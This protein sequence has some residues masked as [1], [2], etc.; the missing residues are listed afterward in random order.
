MSAHRSFPPAP[1][2]ESAGDYS[3]V[4]PMGASPRGI[5]PFSVLSNPVNELRAG[6]VPQGDPKAFVHWTSQASCASRNAS[7]QSPFCKRRAVWSG[8]L[9]GQAGDPAKEAGRLIRCCRPGAVGDVPE[10]ACQAALLEEVVEGLPTGP[11]GAGGLRF[12]LHG[13]SRLPERAVVARILHGNP[14]R[15]RLQA[16][17]PGARIEE[18]ALHTRVELGAA[19]AAP[20]GAHVRVGQL[21]CAARATDD[22]P[23][24]HQVQGARPLGL[25]GART[26]ILRPRRPRRFPAVVLVPALSVLLV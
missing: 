4:A 13:R 22:L 17:Q 25:V 12:A 19:L 23:P 3:V 20:R 26:R 9:V 24:L 11:G 14:R 16:L 2:S 7:F 18:R 5:E 1:T 10:L 8:Q 6:S 21:A 15:N